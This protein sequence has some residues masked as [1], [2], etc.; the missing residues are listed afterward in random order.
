MIV[1]DTSVIYAL[2]DRADGRHAEVLDWYRSDDPEFVTTPLVLAE[3][4]HLAATRAGPQAHEAWLRDIAA[5]AYAIQWWRAAAPQAAAIAR[6]YADL[7]LGLT[8][9]SVVNLC[10]RLGTEQIATLDEQHF[11]AVRPLSGA[12]AFRLLPADRLR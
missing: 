2:L 3:V 6:Q 5:G 8:D 4:D 11:R 12:S 10:A 9:A 7:G 1:V